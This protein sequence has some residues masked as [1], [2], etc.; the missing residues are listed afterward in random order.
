MIKIKEKFVIAIVL[1]FILI[2]QIT[3]NGVTVNA[4]TNTPDVI[5]GKNVRFFLQEVTTNLI[6]VSSI[7]SKWSDKDVKV[8][9]TLRDEWADAQA[10]TISPKTNPSV[11]DISAKVYVKNNKE[12]LYIAIDLQSDKTNDP[13]DDFVDIFFVNFGPMKQNSTQV[14]YHVEATEK[15]SLSTY[16]I[17]K[18]GKNIFTSKIDRSLNTIR[19]EAGASFNNNRIYELKVALNDPAL[20]IDKNGILHMKLLVND[21]KSGKKCQYCAWEVGLA[22]SKGQPGK[23]ANFKEMISQKLVPML[24]KAYETFLILTKKAPYNGATIDIKYTIDKPSSFG[25]PIIINARE[26]LPYL[27]SNN[28][29][30]TYLYP[31]LHQLAHDFIPANSPFSLEKPISA[32]YADLLTYEFFKQTK[33]PYSDWYGRSVLKKYQDDKVPFEKLVWAD[34]HQ[35][36]APYPANALMYGI[37]GEFLQKYGWKPFTQMGMMEVGTPA[38]DRTKLNLFTQT[39]SKVVGKDVTPDF[40]D[41]WKF[42]IIAPNSLFDFG[43]GKIEDVKVAQGESITKQ[44]KVSLTKWLPRTV[45]FNV[46]GLP[47]GAKLA[48]DPAKGEPSFD[49]KLVISTALNTPVG[50]YPI[51]IIALGGDKNHTTSFKLSVAKVTDLIR[52][53]LR[54]DKILVTLSGQFKLST[55]IKSNQTTQITNKYGLFIDNKLVTAQNYTLNP[56]Q[57]KPLDFTWNS[58]GIDPKVLHTAQVKMLA[59]DKPVLESNKIKFAVFEPVKKA[60]VKSNSIV[61]TDVVAKDPDTKKDYTIANVG[62]IKAQLNTKGNYD[63]KLVA[64][65]GRVI[66]GKDGLINSADPIKIT[67]ELNKVKINVMY[68]GHKSKEIFTIEPVS[69]DKS[70]PSGSWKIV[71]VGDPKGTFNVA[72][73]A[74]YI[75]SPAASNGFK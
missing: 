61:I 27:A 32:G 43:L 52:L 41:R 11:S 3:T 15:S 19:S 16:S 72:Y 22:S 60:T 54:S 20:K 33:I 35:P 17:M 47:Q 63:M 26:F 5:E 56:K 58:K 38:D 30:D 51:T 50:S 62:S 12:F 73:D 29:P 44:M 37:L 4:Q 2:L 42:P 74:R 36:K 34:E 8:D 55:T 13:K 71:V 53:E 1:S 48:F 10:V 40:R 46:K 68:T 67:F 69:K 28:L 75:A 57:P 45:S 7:N 64:P 39:L 24:D 25:N 70:L 31:F 6:P 65:D 14:I 18:D 21:A 23:A 49:T 9:G 59:G 66:I